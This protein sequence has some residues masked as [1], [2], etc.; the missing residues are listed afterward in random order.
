MTTNDRSYKNWCKAA[1]D[2]QPY[3]ETL[4]NRYHAAAKKVLKQ[5]AE[6]LELPPS[7][8]TIRTNK[9][10]PAVCGETI[11][12]ADYVYVM[13]TADGMSP[14]QFMWRLCRGRK[15][16]Y[17]LQNN[18]SRCET[19]ADPVKLAKTIRDLATRHGLLTTGATT[20]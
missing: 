11:L 8:Y 1:K 12:H 9:A 10:G 5:L 17:G 20:C 16:Y 6:A 15:D 13:L 19:L 18:W 7:Q 3:N 4:K 14:D 2:W